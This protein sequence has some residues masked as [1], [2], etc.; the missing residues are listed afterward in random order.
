MFTRGGSAG[1]ID[2]QGRIG[3]RDRERRFCAAARFRFDVDRS[4]QSSGTRSSRLT[5]PRP[6]PRA[7]VPLRS[8]PLPSSAIDNWT[9]LRGPGQLQVDAASLGMLT[10]V[11][12]APPA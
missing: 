5:R 10:H 8:N 2:G 12:R 4:T 3:R 6:T 9:A 11:L 7:R 1:G